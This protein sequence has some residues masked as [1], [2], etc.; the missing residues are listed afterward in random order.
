MKRMHQVGLFALLWLTMSA[1][2]L[3]TPIVT[4]SN[5]GQDFNILNGGEFHA[6][7]NGST[8]EMFCI[9]WLNYLTDP[10]YNA[11]LSDS[12]DL[13]HTRYGNT[14]PANFLVDPVNP[15]LT[16]LQRYTMVAYIISTYSLNPANYQQDAYRQEAIWNLMTPTGVSSTPPG[17][18]DSNVAAVITAALAYKDDA[19]LRAA[20]RVV[21]STTTTSYGTGQQ[22]FMYLNS[23]P[24]PGTYALI[25]LGLTGI[26]LLRRRR[27]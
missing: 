4:V 25:G 26:G 27:A 14:A 22:E 1:V 23:V 8:V 11:Y 17:Y 21:T 9:D 19:S 2:A 5:V 20:F 3:A 16:A 15:D 13:S 18:G 7:I 24:E 6:T 10:T 12:S